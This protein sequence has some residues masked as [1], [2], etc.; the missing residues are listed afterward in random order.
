MAWAL[1]GLYPGFPPDLSETKEE[2]VILRRWNSVGDGRSHFGTTMFFLSARCWKLCSKWTDVI[3]VRAK[4][5]EEPIS[6]V[7]DLAKALMRF[8][9]LVVWAWAT[10]FNFAKT[11]LTCAMRLLRAPE[12]GS[13]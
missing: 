6:L 7:L 13:A 3:T 5:T 9:R 8:R 1:M 11:F 4:R 12:A 10:S 2:L